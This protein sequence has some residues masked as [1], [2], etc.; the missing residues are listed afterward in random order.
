MRKKALIG[1]LLAALMLSG[2]AM[3]PKDM[4]AGYM[5]TLAP[6]KNIRHASAGMRLVVSLPSAA[7][8]LDTYRVA[9]IRNGRI[10]DYYAGARWADFLPV[11]VQDSLIKTIENSGIFMAAA[12]QTGLEGDRILRTEIRIFQAEYKKDRLPPTVKIRMVVS[13][14]NHQD[15]KIL[16]SFEI[17]AEKE[18]ARDSLSSIHA[19]FKSAYDE[20]QRR[21]I[22]KLERH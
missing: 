16:S 19:A 10:Q 14:L 2:C 11:L 6:E 8:E 1:F 17:G 13:L 20:T 5:F 15:R 12:D 4:G 22:A 7:P 9:L 21:L 18:A 3:T